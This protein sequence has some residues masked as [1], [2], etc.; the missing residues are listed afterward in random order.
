MTAPLLTRVAQADAAAIADA[1]RVLASGGL[2]AFP[3]ETVYGLGADATNGRAVARLYEAKGRPAF[4]PL[5]AH[6]PD[7]AAYAPVTIPVVEQLDG[8]H[9]AYDK[10]VSLLA[11]Y[12]NSEALAVAREDAKI[13][14][15][16]RAAAV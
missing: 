5:I 15:L 6:V 14:S 12:G 11:P 10:M 8:V 7:A 2:I 16:L 3:T 9:L 13:E 1:V 4:N